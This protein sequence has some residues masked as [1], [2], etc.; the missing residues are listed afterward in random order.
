MA[1][2]VTGSQLLW[3]ISALVRTSPLLYLQWITF[4]HV[5]GFRHTRIGHMWSR[6]FIRE[7]KKV[8]RDAGISKFKIGRD[9]G[10]SI[11]GCRYLIED[12]GISISTVEGDILV[13]EGSD[14][15][16]K[17]YLFLLMLL[18]VIYGLWY[19]NS[20]NK[21]RATRGMHTFYVMELWNMRKYKNKYC[22]HYMNSKCLWT[23]SL[24]F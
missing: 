17:K 14:Y 9:A 18:D 22:L 20:G 8:R 11:S 7:R 16:I 1:A 4:W 24:S 6:L 15:C 13:R 21:M 5:A 19:G 3:L 12:A 10:S 2:A 23:R